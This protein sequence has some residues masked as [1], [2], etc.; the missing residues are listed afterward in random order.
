[1]SSFDEKVKTFISDIQ[2]NR[3]IAANLKNMGTSLTQLKNNREIVIQY[4]NQL[5][6]LK[7][8]ISFGK[9]AY[10][11]KIDFTWSETLKGSNW[12]SNNVNFEY[13]NTLFNL[14]VMSF[15][16]AQEQLKES[17]E[18]ASLK[19]ATKQYRA[20]AGIFDH[21]K[22]DAPANISPKELPYD[23]QAPYMSYC[24]CLSIAFGQVELL[25]IAEAKTSGRD[26]QAKLSKGISDL[27][28]EAYDISTGLSSIDSLYNE[29]LLN[30]KIYWESQM[31]F[32]L[33]QNSI[34]I[35]DK[36]GEDFG[37]AMV[38]QGFAYQKMLDY[39]K[40]LSKFKQFTNEMDTFET[41]RAK[42]EA[43]G[44]DMYEKNNKIYHQA[45]PDLDQEK[46]ESKI[47]VVAQFPSEISSQIEGAN[48]LD[49]LM[50]KEIRDM[51]TNY[52]SK[53]MEI[54]TKA[55]DECENET[56]VFNFL[57]EHG[58]PDLIYGGTKASKLHDGLWAGIVEVQQKGGPMKILHTIEMIK[59]KSIELEIKI[60]ETLGRMQQEDQEDAR[61][62]NQFGVK[63]NRAQSLQINR[64]MLDS[65]SN[66]LKTLLNTRKYDEKAKEELMENARHFER[67]MCSREKL[68]SLIPGQVDLS[69]TKITKEGEEIKKAID[70]INEITKKA[71]DIITNIFKDL[72]EKNMGPDFMKVLEKE[73]TE[74]LIFN[75]NKALFEIKFGELKEI[76]KQIKQK[77]DD[78]VV[79]AGKLI[80]TQPR[81]NNNAFEKEK[82][83]SE[84]GQLIDMYH[85]K[86]KA[87]MKG[88]DYYVTLGE[89][90]DTLIHQVNELLSS[91]EFE[92]NNLIQAIQGG[93]PYTNPNLIPNPNQYNDPSKII[94]YF[95][96]N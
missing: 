8:K 68:E 35:F 96:F 83:Q 77:K 22:I 5:L 26:L 84:L 87:I 69:Q 6:T 56:T 85:Q 37:K 17:K 19:E 58:L 64:P 81:S 21:I 15:L 11:L 45:V 73:T 51:I 52:K 30:R 55:L 28:Q 95:I 61:L 80:D 24:S 89:K 66:F 23:L 86:Y 2:Q 78:I 70:E 3:A 47:M 57:Q 75:T 90:I 63:W 18:E 48:E 16:I 49:S 20:A 40:S 53:M 38:Y 82:Y 79:K 54:I 62:R 10:C 29:Y 34:D 27:Y 44:Q 9:E 7:T 41:K 31:F 94:Y 14:G 50:S 43:V 13:Y 93:K 33:K 92:K 74:I 42:E 71:M 12:S 32:K 65:L 67:L 25:H 72:N 4:L 39:G 60:N 88:Y 91:R 46:Y 76:S 1:M 36:R 59:A